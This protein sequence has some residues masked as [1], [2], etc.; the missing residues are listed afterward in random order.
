MDGSPGP[1]EGLVR[2]S[3]GN[4]ETWMGGLVAAQ[5]RMPPPFLQHPR[6]ALMTPPSLRPQ[7]GV[8]SLTIS[9]FPSGVQCRQVGPGMTPCL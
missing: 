3:A 8:G 2:G 9:P 1:G 5:L 6:P 4:G 7:E